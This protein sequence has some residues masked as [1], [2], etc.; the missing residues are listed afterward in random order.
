MMSVGIRL[1]TSSITIPTCCVRSN[2]ASPLLCVTYTFPGVAAN[3]G[4][5]NGPAYS[6]RRRSP[7]FWL[8]ISSSAT[9][10]APPQRELVRATDGGDPTGTVVLSVYGDAP[11]TR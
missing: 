10:S 11:R 3:T 7:V 6:S 4:G 1:S 8:S 2:T 5:R 9:V